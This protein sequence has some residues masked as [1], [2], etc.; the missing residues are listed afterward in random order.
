M[1]LLGAGIAIVILVRFYLNSKN[2]RLK[3]DSFKL[4]APVIGKSVVR[5]LAARF[6]RTMA[7]LASTGIS[8]TQALVMSAQVGRQQACGKSYN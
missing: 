5:I 8:L 2:G 3:W 6:S 1:F 4:R 7:T